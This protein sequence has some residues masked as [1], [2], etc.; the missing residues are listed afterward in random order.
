M[1]K[2]VES[3]NELLSHVFGS[4]R[5]IEAL[6]GTVSDCDFIPNVG[7][8]LNC[9]CVEVTG[10][11]ITAGGRSVRGCISEADF[12]MPSERYRRF[13][14]ARK[15]DF[16][17]PNAYDRLIVVSSLDLREIYVSRGGRGRQKLVNLFDLARVLSRLGETGEVKL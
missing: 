2:K 12:A 14:M 15:G 1:G 3:L 10:R 7:D 16:I 4:D 17:P 13:F 8:T 5:E 6:R 9:D 11:S